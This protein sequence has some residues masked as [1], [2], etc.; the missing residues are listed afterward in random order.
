MSDNKR[1]VSNKKCDCGK[2][3]YRDKYIKIKQIKQIQTTNCTSFSRFIRT[4]ISKRTLLC[5]VLYLFN[6]VFFYS[7]KLNF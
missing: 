7:F 4:K 1:V 5:G 3:L 6:F 2:S